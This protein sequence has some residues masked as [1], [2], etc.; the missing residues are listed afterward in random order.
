MVRQWQSLRR[1]A[2]QVGP[3]ATTSHCGGR[4]LER[5]LLLSLRA[6]L[7][8][9]ANVPFPG[10]RLLGSKHFAYP[11][12]VY[13]ASLLSALS[14]V[15]CGPKFKVVPIV[16]GLLIIFVFPLHIALKDQNHICK[17]VRL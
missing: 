12:P 8:K 15:G 16:L 11:T 2:T 13:Q 9:C 10:L 5:P 17:P 6:E 7:D 14:G 4:D 3:F 1:L